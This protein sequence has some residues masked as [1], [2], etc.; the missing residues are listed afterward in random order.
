[1]HRLRDLL[2][3]RKLIA[4]LFGFATPAVLVVCIWTI[5]W[6]VAWLLC[7]S[8]W[9]VALFWLYAAES[10]AHPEARWARGLQVLLWFAWCA[11]LLSS[12]LAMGF[13]PASWANYWYSA[14][15]ESFS[16]G[17][18]SVAFAASLTAGFAA[19]LVVI[20]SALRRQSGPE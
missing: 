17:L 7:S 5:P 15:Q 2:H 3:S 14:W 9:L 12:S 1:M 20:V 18:V 8:T 4:C 13:G 11:W 19:S 10:S 16:E 6:P